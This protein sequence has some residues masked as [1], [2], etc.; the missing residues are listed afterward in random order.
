MFQWFKK[1]AAGTKS[2]VYNKRYFMLLCQFCEFFEVGYI[3]LGVANRFQVDCFG[4]L[5]DQGF[6][7]FNLV[8][9]RKAGFNTQSLESHFELIV[10]ASIQIRC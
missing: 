9:I 1:V 5:V 6:K 10:G 3:E 8:S 7:S 4:I 2:I